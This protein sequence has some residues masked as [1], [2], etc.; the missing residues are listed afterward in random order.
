MKMKLTSIGVIILLVMVGFIGLITLESEV[1]KAGTILYVG[2]GGS[3]N[4]THIQYAIE[5]ASDGLTVFVYSGTYYE[6]VV[7]DKTINLVGENWETTIIDSGGDDDA[8]HISAD[9]V[10]VTGFTMTNSGSTWGKAGIEIY[11]SDHCRIE[12]CNSSNNKETGI[13]LYHSSNNTIVNNNCSNNNAG[14]LLNSLSNGNTLANNTCN[15]NFWEGIF[16]YSSSINNT[17]VNNTCS[18]NRDGIRLA[19]GNNNVTG[20]FISSNTVNGVYLDSSSSNTIV[21]NTCSNNDHGIHFM[22]SS[23]NNITGNIISDNRYGIYH[24]PSSD[25][26]ITENYI[27]NNDDG[28]Y[29]YLSSGNRIYH[30]NFLTNGNQAIDDE[31]NNYWDDGYP[32]G[33]NYW[34]DYSGSDN[35]IG[36]DQDSNG[37]DGIGDTPYEIDADSID[38]YPLIDPYF[39]PP[40]PLIKLLSPEDNSVISP[41]TTLNFWVYDDNLDYVRYTIDG[42]SWFDFLQ[43]YNI[44]TSGWADGTHTVGIQAYDTIGSS[45]YSSFDFTIDT[46]PPQCSITLP[47]SGGIVSGQVTVTGDASDLTSVE[48]VW[49]KIDNG[50]WDLAT[51]T[52]SWEYGWDTTAV[53]DGDHS[54]SAAAYDEA[55]N[56]G[57]IAIEVTVDNS[58]LTAPSAPQNF[59]A[60]SGDGYVNLTWDAPVSDGGSPIAGYDI[61]RGTTSG[62]ETYLGGTGNVLFYNDTSVTNDI[63]YYY[64]VSAENGI[65]EGSQSNEL[66]ARPGISS[67]GSDGDKKNGDTDF[68]NLLIANIHYIIIAIII[69]CLLIVVLLV[70]KSKMEEK[71]ALEKTQEEMVELESEIQ[72]MKEK[73][74]KTDELEKTLEE[75]KAE[76]KEEGI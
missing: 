4:F 35:K 1:A 76:L 24:G 21:N 28:I 6:N 72:T 48:S 40:A 75:M 30:N 27:S 8:V 9:W 74:I 65:G 33:G 3:G 7:V 69:I 16:L 36:P 60:V 38:R 62:A 68:I 25:N 17:L 22:S 39:D 53:A 55:E 14:I 44:S 61:Y 57:S 66:M 54:I 29:L 58:D 41:V 10:N 37:S 43:P 73:G 20:N 45:S 71:R 23:N 51:G 5:N 64:K 12:Y 2:S 32:S 34:S 49:V 19:S 56:W 70:G 63:T 13:Y 52:T 59:I 11:Y 46:T 26:N 50:S 42:G 18:N 15:F 67:S 47:T 31:A